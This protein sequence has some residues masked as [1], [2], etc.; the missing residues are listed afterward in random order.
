[1]WLV[2]WQR[3]NGEG[4]HFNKIYGF[5]GVFSLGYPGFSGFEFFSSL[6][7]WAHLMGSFQFTSELKIIPLVFDEIFV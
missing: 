2:P 6:R 5:L 3:M 7:L 4:V 1:M